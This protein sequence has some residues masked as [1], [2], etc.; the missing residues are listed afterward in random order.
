LFKIG[1]FSKLMQISIRMLRYYD[2]AGLLKPAQIDE[3]TGYRLYS[4]AQIPVLQRI[5]L[6][7][8]V[9]FSVAEMAVA[10]AHGDERAFIGELERKKAELEEELRLERQRIARIDRALRDIREAGP[11]HPCE[12]SFKSIPPLRILSLRKTIPHYHCEGMLWEQLFRFIERE[13]PEL[14][15]QSHRNLAIYHDEEH[16]EADVDVEVGVLV[17]WAGKNGDGCSF[18]ETEPVAN[19]ACLMVHGPYENLERAYQS[20]ACWLERNQYRMTGLSRQICH[21]GPYNEADPDQY[22]T[23][24]QNPVRSLA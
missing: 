16:K 1:E 2:E 14:R 10:L 8:D 15:Q 20:F 12:V 11:T 13:H 18:R 19:M 9:K 4:A 3:A 22:L 17:E 24:I 7:R 6:L 21:K 5:K 23:E